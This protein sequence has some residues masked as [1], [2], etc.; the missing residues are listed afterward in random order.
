MMNGAVDAM[1]PHARFQI[2]ATRESSRRRNLLDWKV[3]DRPVRFRRGEVGA[4]M[5]ADWSGSPPLP[6]T[7]ARCEPSSASCSVAI[8]CSSLSKELGFLQRCTPRSSAKRALALGRRFHDIW[9]V[10]GPTSAAH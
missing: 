6:D 10:S 8:R 5:G 2:A 4:L 1:L 3:D 7:A 9:S